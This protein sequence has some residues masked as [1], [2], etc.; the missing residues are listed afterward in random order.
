MKKILSIAT[1][2]ALALVVFGLIS[3]KADAN[4]SVFTKFDDSD[5]ETAKQIS[6]AIIRQQASQRAIGNADD[7]I[8]SRVEFDETRM[9]HTHIQ[10]RIGKIPVWEGEAI[11]H[12]RPDG[13]LSSITDDLKESVL[14]ST[15][16]AISAGDAANIALAI[17]GNPPYLTERPRTDLLIFRGDDRDHLVYRVQFAMVEGF[18][19]PTAPAVFID[20]HTGE[21]VFEYNNLKTGTGNSLYS[22]TVTISTS[23]SGSSFYMEDTVR[24]MGTF[25]MNSTGNES[26]GTGGTMSRFTDTDDNWNTTIQRAGVDAHFGAAMTFDYFKN[27]HGRNGIDGNYG[28]GTVTSAVGGVSLVASRVHFGTSGRYNNAFWYN[29][30]MSYGDGDGS[31]FSPLTTLDICGHEM[32]HGITERTANLTYARESGALNESWSDAF[33]AMVELY[34]RGGS[35]TADTWKIGEQAYTPSNG[36]G[37]ALRYMD[38]P[39]AAGD[40]DHYSE[41][42]YPGTCTPSNA[43]DQCGVHTNSAIANKAFYLVVAGGTHPQ[44]GVTV[45]GAGATAGGKIWY[46]ALTQYMTSGTNFAG[47]RTA[48]LNAATAL[49]GSGSAQYNTVAGAWCAVGVGTCPSGPTPTPTA[50][51]TPNPTPTP[52]PT[53][54]P[55]PTPT[56][57]P[58]G[59]LLINGEFEGSASPWI[60]SGSGYFYVS[61]GNYP[62][63][64]TGY[65]YF[66]VNNSVT[67]QAYQTVSIPS[68][69]SGT[70]SFRL[71]VN[72]NETTTS[73]QYDRLFV[74]VRNTSG[75]LL[76]TL[77]TYSNLNK[78]AAGVYTLRTHSLSAYRGQTVRIQFRVSND[79]SLP[80][81]FRV[82]NVTLN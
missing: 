59:N 67:G 56:P 62:Y 48:T 29:N 45:S 2:A 13:E 80:T 38:N 73:S 68:S 35:P 43:N 9:A 31:T 19:Q 30:Q 78:A 44:S 17:Y 75:T 47:A 14:V 26:S 37:D 7:L 20:A 81:T 15:D 41:R 77:G 1:F 50:T 51:P 40:P 63:A 8:V 39:P 71:N 5:K 65:I 82:D 18:D 10:Q 60:G 16:P 61:N 23:G 28:P 69:A 79:Y 22:G 34:A 24:R 33:G 54:T 25:N 74:E 12:L 3:N 58:G 57:T 55:N 27:V 64:G 4:R 76:A 42:L 11:V 52:T 6:L 53:P 70:L 21:K 72:S 36:T 46:L 32:A 66:G 49:Y